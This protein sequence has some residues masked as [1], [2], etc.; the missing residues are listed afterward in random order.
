[1][2]P[3]SKAAFISSTVKSGVASSLSFIDS[4]NTSSAVLIS[5]IVLIPV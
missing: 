2:R 4:E 5:L 3:D 1:M